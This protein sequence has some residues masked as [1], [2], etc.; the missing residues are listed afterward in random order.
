M[1][2]PWR[3]RMVLRDP[4]VDAAVL[5]TARGGIVRA[6]LGCRKCDVGAVLNVTADHLGLRRHRH[7]RAAGRGQAGR[8][9]GGARTARVLNADDELVA[10]DGRAT[11]RRS[12]SA[13]SP[14]TRDARA[15]ARAHPRRRPGGGA[16]GGAATASMIVL[17]D[18]GRADPAAVDAP[19]PGDAR[20]ARAAQRAERDVRRRDRATRWAS[21]S[22][23]IRQ[24]L[25]TFDT[26]FFQTPGPDERLQRA[27]VPGASSTTATTRPRSAP[28][29]PGRALH[30]CA[31][32][33]RRARRAGRPPRRG[34]RAIG[35]DRRRPLRPLHLPARRQPAR[36]R[37]RRGAE[38]ARGG[39][40]RARGPARADHA[41]GGRAG[42]GAGE[43]WSWPSPTTCC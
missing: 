16:G 14:C 38:A 31:G 15:G 17:Y 21:R 3:A 22:T 30:R 4:T 20:R 8:R 32:A 10:E 27:S 18:N 43:R 19:D 24:G 26:D 11:P 2:G 42:R 39:A 5:E 9:R 29:R 37:G 33:D 1:T 34:H 13:T 23:N 7:A 25:R 6:G 28:W 41:D 35:G 12:T 36:P 40:A